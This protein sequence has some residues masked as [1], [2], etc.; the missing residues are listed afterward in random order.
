MFV[1]CDILLSS[2]VSFYATRN[3]TCRLFTGTVTCLLGSI[4]TIV[5]T[6]LEGY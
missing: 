4:R 5:L 1:G 2:I 3:V 6:S